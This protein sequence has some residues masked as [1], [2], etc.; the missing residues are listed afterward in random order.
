[1]YLYVQNCSQNGPLKQN[2]R[3]CSV[4]VFWVQLTFVTDICS[5]RSSHIVKLYGIVVSVSCVML[6]NFPSVHVLAAIHIIKFNY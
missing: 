4:R 6:C 3:F 1:M 2:I 5:V